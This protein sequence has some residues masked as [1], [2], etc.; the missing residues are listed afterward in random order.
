MCECA[1]MFVH[2]YEEPKVLGCQPL[3][4]VHLVLLRVTQWDLGP[5]VRLGWQISHLKRSACVCALSMGITSLNYHICLFT[6][7]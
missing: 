1:C 3:E 6:G 2:M 4:A 7:C 5:E